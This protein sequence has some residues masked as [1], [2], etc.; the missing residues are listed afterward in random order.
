MTINYAIHA[1]DAVGGGT[2][3]FDAQNGTY[4]DVFFLSA[5][6]FFRIAYFLYISRL[7]LFYCDL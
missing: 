6:N 7:S 2:L 3:Y 4:T 1:V 5:G